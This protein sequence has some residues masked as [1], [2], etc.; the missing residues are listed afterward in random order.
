MKNIVMNKKAYVRVKILSN[1]IQ[2]RFEQIDSPKQP[3]SFDLLRDRLYQ[4]IPNAKW[5]KQIRWMVIPLD[6]LNN[7]LDFCYREFGSGQV[8]IENKRVSRPSTQMPFR[9]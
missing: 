5:N 2:L 6:Q 1:S 8:K 3:R 9:F 4:E 7:V